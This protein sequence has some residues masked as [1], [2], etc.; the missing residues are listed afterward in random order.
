ML[1]ER[2][3]G[4]L[5]RLYAALGPQ[6]RPV[7]GNPC[8]E[9]KACCTAEGMTYHRVSELELELIA[10][11]HGPPEDFRRYLERATDADGLLLHQD[12]PNYRDGGCGIYDVRPF[13]CRLFGHVREAGTCLPEGCSFRGHESEFA[14]GDYFKTV[15]ETARLRRLTREFRVLLPVAREY[16]RPGG[17]AG[18]APELDYLD[19]EDPQ[20]RA[21]LLQVQG[22]W[23]EALAELLAAREAEP[24]AYL[25]YSLGLVLGSLDRHEEALAAFLRARSEAPERADLPYYA[26]YH[27]LMLGRGEEGRALLEEAVRLDPAHS[28]ALGFLGYHFLQAGD[29]ARARDYFARASQADP[30]NPYFKA[31]LE[32][33]T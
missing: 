7:Q 15:P 3:L 2:L 31:R 26:G 23:Q 9:C 5:E 14:R 20:D 17:S 1:R 27:L 30:G 24:S 16:V 32:A 11:R 29:A 18:D 13:S 10:A 33:M 4:E 22:R 25:D 12:C 8:G 6:L 21:L 28:L 19:L